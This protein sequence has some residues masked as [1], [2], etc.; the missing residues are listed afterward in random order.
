MIFERKNLLTV[1]VKKSRRTPSQEGGGL[2][3]TTVIPPVFLE[4]PPCF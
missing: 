4:N 2:R 1:G 3:E